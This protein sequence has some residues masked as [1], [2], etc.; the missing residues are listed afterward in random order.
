MRKQIYLFNNLVSIYNR[1]RAKLARLISQNKNTRKQDILKRRISRLFSQLSGLNKTIRLGFASVAL[2]AGSALI[3]SNE[4][5]AQ[6]QFDPELTNPF[7]LT[8]SYLNKPSLGD[9]DSDGDL[10]LMV[11]DTLGNLRYFKN[12][13]T[14]SAPAFDPVVVNP[15]SLSASPLPYFSAPSFA[16]LDTDGDMDVILGSTYGDF[17]YYQNTGTPTAPA[18]AAPV[19]NP[20]S[21]ANIGTYLA[22]P[23]FADLDNDG[24][25][26][27]IT[28]GYDGLVRYFPN[29]GTATAP[30]FDPA[31]PNPYGMTHVDLYLNAVS[32]G[33][34]DGDGDLDLMMGG[35][36]DGGSFHY[37][38][39]SGTASAPAFGAAVADTFNLNPVPGGLCWPDMGDLDNDGDVDIISG[40]YYGAFY[41]YKHVPYVTV[42]EITNTYNVSVF[43]N[44]ASEKITIGCGNYTASKIVLCDATGREIETFLPQTTQF[45]INM[46]NYEAGVYLVRTFIENEVAIIK[47]VKK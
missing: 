44:P 34:V 18:F 26:D 20:F 29:T 13:G 37:Y 16:D 28:G 42:K 3:P 9:L 15:F 45:A 2:V 23:E 25:L 10:D 6:Q 5:K 31:I 4:V 11:S 35:I 47:V 1:S 39:N 17:Y 27:M 38:E 8:F 32:F 14:A 36:Y 12:S 19:M 21:L 43:P 22:T 40:S 7:G 46:S 41:Y 30:S 24:D 33:D